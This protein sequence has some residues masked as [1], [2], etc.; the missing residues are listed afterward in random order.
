MYTGIICA[1][2]PAV[3]NAASDFSAHAS[4]GFEYPGRVSWPRTRAA[5]AAD[6]Q[7]NQ[8]GVGALRQSH[9]LL[10]GRD[11]DEWKVRSSGVPGQTRPCN[12]VQQAPSGGAVPQTLQVGK[13]SRKIDTD[14]KYAISG[15]HSGYA[16]RNC[17]V[18]LRAVTLPPHLP[19]PVYSSTTPSS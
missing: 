7:A 11:G 10:G 1:S 2:A 17:E 14:V 5:G 16:V 4:P 6:G 8:G 9:P 18:F 12:S 3:T 13:A 15:P 19:C